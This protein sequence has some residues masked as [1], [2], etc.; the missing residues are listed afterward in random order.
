MKQEIEKWERVFLERERE[1]DREIWVWRWN[2]T[3]EHD[4]P[5]AVWKG[6]EDV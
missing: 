6:V 2:E 3:I 4:T 5:A 1:S